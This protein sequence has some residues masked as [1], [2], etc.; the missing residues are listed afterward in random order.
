MNDAEEL[1]APTMA[2]REQDV[3]H[4]LV[5]LT[6]GRIDATQIEILAHS[7][8]IQGRTAISD[9]RDA[10]L[11]ILDAIHVLREHAPAMEIKVRLT[12]VRA[13]RDSSDPVHICSE[14]D[15]PEGDA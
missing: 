1:V 7:I 11:Q 2:D 3:R 10:S 12:L 9:L 5:A 14:I 13:R 15:K 4:S 6:A 8:Q